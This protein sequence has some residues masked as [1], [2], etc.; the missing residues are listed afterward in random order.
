MIFERSNH[1]EEPEIRALNKD[2]KRY[3]RYNLAASGA[4]V[5][6]LC[7]LMAVLF[8]VLTPLIALSFAGNVI[9]RI[10][11]LYSFDL[12]RTLVAEDINLNAQSGEIASLLS[13]YMMHKRDDFQIRTEYQGIE[14]P[15]FTL[16]D[17]LAVGRYRAFLDTTFAA[18][19]VMFP[20]FIAFFIL[21]YH[22]GRKR[23][24]RRAYWGGI[25]LFFVLLLGMAELVRSAA[26]RFMLLHDVL[27]VNFGIGDVL[28]QLFGDG[29]RLEVFI[30]VFVISVIL[31]I[32][33]N[34]VT[35]ILTRDE[36]LFD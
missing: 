23:Y 33:G 18:F 19:C 32:V 34:S 30:A 1:K 13:D 3:R 17:G 15:V 5:S 10:P 25:A 9:F 24:L 20:L 4:V 22:L 2:I 28:P 8:A 11:D 7:K 16:N 14:K 6:F 12:E 27:K 31:I 35:R 29:Y 21:L 26:L 36:R